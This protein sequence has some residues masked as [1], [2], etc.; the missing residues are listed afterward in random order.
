MVLQ[1]HARQMCGEDAASSASRG[2]ASLPKGEAR[3]LNKCF[4][5]DFPDLY[6]VKDDNVF[7]EIK[8]D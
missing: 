7:N 3:V 4:F 2:D 6:R 5:L 8:G 1:L